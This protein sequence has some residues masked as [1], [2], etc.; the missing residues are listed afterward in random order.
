M[1]ST[2]IGDVKVEGAQIE[3]LQNVVDSIQDL[4]QE[5]VSLK[6]SMAGCDYGVNVDKGELLANI[7]LAYRELENSIFRTTLVMEEIKNTN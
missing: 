7:T 4:I 2:E 3:N 5:L 6:K 1:E